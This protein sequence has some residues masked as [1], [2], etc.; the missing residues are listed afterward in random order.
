VTAERKCPSCKRVTRYIA[1]NAIRCGHC[2]DDITLRRGYG[3][4]TAHMSTVEREEFR[5]Q[6]VEMFQAGRELLR[7]VEEDSEK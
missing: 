2:L 1:P 4:V 6:A 3:H 7:L 5:R